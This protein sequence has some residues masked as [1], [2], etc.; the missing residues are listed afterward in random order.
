[1][2]DTYEVISAFL[3][4]EPFDSS[5]LAEAL[6]EPGGRDLLIDLLALR[7][8][9]QADGKEGPVLFEK[10]RRSALHALVAVAAV[11]LAL[12]GG[13][14][15]GQRRSEADLSSGAPAATRVVDAPAAWQELP[16]TRMR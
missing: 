15:L 13:Y 6:S 4:D 2:S 5:Q 9:V 1:M 3:D 8:L 10:P 16:T 14:L 11:F 7:H 12:G